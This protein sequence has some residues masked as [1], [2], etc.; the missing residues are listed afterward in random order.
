MNKKII[1]AGGTG[2]L[3]HMLAQYFKEKGYDIVVLSR[4][5]VSLEH[6][7]VV[8]WDGESLGEWAGELENATALINLTGRSVNCRYDERNR[9]EILDSRVHSTKILGEAVNRCV[10]PPRVWLNSSTATIYKH[11]YDQANDEKNG[12]I[13]GTKEAKDEFSVQVAQAWESAFQKIVTLSTRKIILRMAMVM[14]NEQGGVYEVLSRL[15]RFGLG[16]KMGHGRQ[17][18]S[19][20]HSADLCAAMEWLINNPKA[21]GIYNICSPNPVPNQ[22]MMEQFRKSLGVSI[23]LPATFWML[24]IGTFLMQT[25]SELVIKS[26]NVVPSR[27]ISE[28]FKFKYPEFENALAELKH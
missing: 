25:E 6:A 11:S 1:L 18:V 23:G 8:H 7:R 20:I 26:R 17:Y 24:E 22:K 14:G 16:G 27:L 4:R 12:I 9:K 3:G 28:G 10:Y 2:F 21:E 19:W 5:R 15:T 13:G